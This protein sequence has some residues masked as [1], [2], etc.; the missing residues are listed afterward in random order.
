VHEEVLD[1]DDEN[2]NK[3]ETSIVNDEP[4]KVHSHHSDEGIETGSQ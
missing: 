4:E 1:L 2:L 3:E